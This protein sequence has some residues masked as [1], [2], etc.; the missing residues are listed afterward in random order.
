[1]PAWRKHAAGPDSS[2]RALHMADADMLSVKAACTSAAE[3]PH[4]LFAIGRAWPA[5]RS[6]GASS[7]PRS[8]AAGRG[9]DAR[10][11]FEEAAMST[12]QLQYGVG[13]DT[14]ACTSFHRRGTSGSASFA[15][16]VVF[17]CSTAIGR[18]HLRDLLQRKVLS[19]PFLSG[20]VDVPVL[21]ATPPA[22][23]QAIKV[24][25][26]GCNPYCARVG[27][28]DALL[29]AAGYSTSASAELVRVNEDT[30]VVSEHLGDASWKLGPTNC[31]NSDAIVAWVLPPSNDLMLKHLPHCFMD[32]D[33]KVVHIKVYRPGFFQPPPPPP[34]AA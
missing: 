34:H 27:F 1:M 25:I 15:V 5:V 8:P 31:G 32:A 12:L 7:T 16:Y 3:K 22:P 2:L 30:H 21:P 33:G 19:V 20:S 14:E 17:N 4:L 24:L 29:Y 10:E 18:S 11:A 23:P 28:M 9:G 26:T 6:S 13:S